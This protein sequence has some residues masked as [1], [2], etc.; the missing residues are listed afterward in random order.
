[1]E[2]EDNCNH[3]SL[4]HAILKACIPE[5][6]FRPLMCYCM[7]EFRRAIRYPTFSIM[8][9]TDPEMFCWIRRLTNVIFQSIPSGADSHAIS[10]Q[11]GSKRCRPSGISIT[12]RSGIAA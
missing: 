8:S 5:L 4:N 11:I 10:T 7:A 2:S 9:M 1:M 12:R 3:S 6:S